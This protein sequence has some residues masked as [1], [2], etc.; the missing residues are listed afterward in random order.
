M[1]QHQTFL[2]EGLLHINLENSLVMFS[3]VEFV[4]ISWP[5]IS[6][7][8]YPTEMCIPGAESHIS[9]CHGSMIYE[10]PN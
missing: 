5:S 7:H 9:Q 4:H 10:A 1:L 2:E 3:E 8:K 6:F